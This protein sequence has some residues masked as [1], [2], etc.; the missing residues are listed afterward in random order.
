VLF[1][2]IAGAVIGKWNNWLKYQNIYWKM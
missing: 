2:G 1:V